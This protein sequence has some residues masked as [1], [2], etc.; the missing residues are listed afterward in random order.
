MWG[1]DSTRILRR[2]YEGERK[3][4]EDAARERVAVIVYDYWKE[5]RL[6][7]T[8]IGKSCGYCIQHDP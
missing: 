3:A 5:L 4:V 7:Y 8:I 2:G 1:L 6:S